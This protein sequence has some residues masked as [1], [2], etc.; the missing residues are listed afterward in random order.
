VPLHPLLQKILLGI[1]HKTHEKM[2]ERHATWLRRFKWLQIILAALTTAGAVG[3]L[4]EQNLSFLPVRD[5]APLDPAF[6]CE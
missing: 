6:D 3:V 2:A 1:F 4:F 5:S